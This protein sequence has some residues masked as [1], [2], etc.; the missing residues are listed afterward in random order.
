MWETNFRIIAY[1]KRLPPLYTREEGLTNS[2]TEMRV[3]FSEGAWGNRSLGI[4]ER[5]P[6]K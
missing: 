5:F 4:K 2:K 3:P 1:K 6:Q